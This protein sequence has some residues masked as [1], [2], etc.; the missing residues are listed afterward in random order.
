MEQS[1]WQFCREPSWFHYLQHLRIFYWR[2]KNS[3][4]LYSKR[5]FIIPECIVVAAYFITSEIQNLT[6]EADYY[7]ISHPHCTWS[8]IPHLTINKFWREIR[9]EV[10]NFVCNF[11]N[12]IVP[13][14]FDEAGDPFFH[15]SALSEAHFIGSSPNMSHT[16]LV[17]SSTDLVSVSISSKFRKNKILIIKKSGPKIK[18]Q[19][20][21]K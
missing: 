5:Q 3:K 16:H 4:L 1:Y 11:S 15:D 20:V 17:I 12:E 8:K 6:K 10:V 18:F 7:K 14:G 9:G 19:H 13:E 2:F 21:V